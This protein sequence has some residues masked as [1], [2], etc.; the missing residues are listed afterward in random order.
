MDLQALLHNYEGKYLKVLKIKVFT[1]ESG[2]GEGESESP[3]RVY[4]SMI[5]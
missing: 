2:K 4:L 5:H 3:F 1:C